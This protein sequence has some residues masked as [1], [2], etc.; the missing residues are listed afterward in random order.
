MIIWLYAD[1]TTLYS[2]IQLPL[3]TMNHSN[4]ELDKVYAWIAIN[5]LSLNIDKTEYVIFHVINNSIEDIM[6]HL[7]INEIQID[8]LFQFSWSQPTRKY[9]LENSYW[10]RYK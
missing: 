4:D 5:K 2:C 6:S 7:V 9:V 8:R 1:D 3:N 10:I